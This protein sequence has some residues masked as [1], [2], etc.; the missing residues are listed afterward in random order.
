M[1]VRKGF[2][3][4]FRNRSCKYLKPAFSVKI[5]LSKHRSLTNMYWHWLAVRLPLRQ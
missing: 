1:V 4:K 5:D 2:E 3:V